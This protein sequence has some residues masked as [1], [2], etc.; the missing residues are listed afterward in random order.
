MHPLD[1]VDP[2]D[3]LD[4]IGALD[5]IDLLHPKQLSSR[6]GQPGRLVPPAGRWAALQG[7]KGRAKEGGSAQEN[8]P[9]PTPITAGAPSMVERGVAGRATLQSAGGGVGASHT[10]TVMRGRKQQWIHSC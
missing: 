3:P 5:L 6:A 2:L 1:P 7:N 10:A 8:A 4:L 9:S